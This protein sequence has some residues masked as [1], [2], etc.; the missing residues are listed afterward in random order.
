MTNYKELTIDAIT[1]KQTIT[2]YSPE[3]IAEAK[4]W[5]AESAERLKIYN[6]KK[7]EKEALLAKLGITADEAAL[8]LA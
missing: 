3:Q 6:L 1:G 7:A 4:I 8:L 5:E 2:D